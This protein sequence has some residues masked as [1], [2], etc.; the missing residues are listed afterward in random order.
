[1]NGK[2]SIQIKAGI[3]IT[4][5]MLFASFSFYAYQLLFTPN[6]QLEKEDTYLYI[7]TGATFAMVKDS[8]DKHEIL[9]DRVSFHFLARLLK[10]RENVKPGRYL[11]K[12]NSN[13]L[14]T[15]KMLKQGRQVPVKLTFNSIRLKTELAEILSKKLEFSS[16]EFLAII[17]DKMEAEKLGLTPNTITAIFIPNTYE[18]YWNISARTFIDK[19]YAEYKKFWTTERLALAKETGLTPPEV[20]TLAS[21][22][23]AETNDNHEKPTIAGVYLNRLKSGMP[24]QADPTLKY[25]LGDF[26]IKRIYSGHIAFDS[27]FNTYMYAGLPPGPINLPS[28]TSVDAVLNYGK[29]KYIYFCADHQL[30]GKHEFAETYEDHLKLA[31]QY[32]KA[33]DKLNIK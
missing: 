16:K 2:K 7:P 25:A 14:T 33:L 26:T 30:T 21:I 19:M 20:V 23:E 10:Y 31:A 12:K 3:I 11:L 32:R 22:V 17:D 13:N 6:V 15:I 27:P 29:H 18:L 5:G 1:M 8:L 4:I 9:N 24:L 28:I